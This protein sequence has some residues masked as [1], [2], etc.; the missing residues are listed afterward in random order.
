MWVALC[1]LS[2][3]SQASLE[4]IFLAFVACKKCKYKERVRMMATG[5]TST[6]GKHIEYRICAED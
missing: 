1:S 4:F 5:E 3:I 2:L 6:V